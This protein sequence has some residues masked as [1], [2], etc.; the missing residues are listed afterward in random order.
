M[1][2]ASDPDVNSRRTVAQRNRL[3]AVLLAKRFS[4]V[5]SVPREAK[6]LIVDDPRNGEPG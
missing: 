6:S 2:S 3:S 5:G 4:L 1:I